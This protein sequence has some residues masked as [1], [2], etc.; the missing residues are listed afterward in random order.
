MGLF[1]LAEARRELT[2]LR[3]VLEVASLLVDERSVRQALARLSTAARD[4]SGVTPGLA[5]TR[6]NDRRRRSRG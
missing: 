3:P 6:M 5:L 2:R 4:A 1:T